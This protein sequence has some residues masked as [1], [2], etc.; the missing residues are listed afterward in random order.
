MNIIINN[1]PGGIIQ[2]TDK[3]IVNV[4]GD[5]NVTNKDKKESVEVADEIEDIV[6]ALH[7]APEICKKAVET[8]LTKQFTMSGTVLNSQAQLRKAVAL[9]DLNTNTQIGIL[10]AIC[11]EVNVVKTNAKNV[12]FVRALIGLGLIEY[13]DDNQISRIAHGFSD[14]IK[15]LSPRH[16]QWNGEDRKLGDKLYDAL[17]QG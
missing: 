5:V 7:E 9:I 17:R 14:K 8:V 11:K 15:N 12:D 2:Q 4:F 16:T 13:E 10:L 3:P 1:Q 6:D